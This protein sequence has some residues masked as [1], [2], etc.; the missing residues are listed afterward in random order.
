MAG[1]HD[2]FSQS[3]GNTKTRGNFIAATFDTIRKTYRILTPDLWGKCEYTQTPFELYAEDLKRS[4]EKKEFGRREGGDF[5]GRRGG[6]RG[7]RGDRG[8]DRRGGDRRN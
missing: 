7:D 6:D 5:Q 4:P 3:K 1:I 8:G 2:V